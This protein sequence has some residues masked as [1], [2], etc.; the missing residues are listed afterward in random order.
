MNKSPLLVVWLFWTEIDDFA[1]RKHLN[2]C[3]H[4]NRYNLSDTVESAVVYGY[5]GG[6]N[7]PGNERGNSSSTL[8]TQGCFWYPPPGGDSGRM[9]PPYPH[10]RRKS[11]LKRDG[12]SEEPWKGWPVSVLGRDRNVKE[13][14]ERSNFLTSSVRLHIYVPSHV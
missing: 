9:G 13:P 2:R 14:Y 8:K 11:R 5:K 10:T 6:M 4:Q 7:I 1:I 12:F 3:T